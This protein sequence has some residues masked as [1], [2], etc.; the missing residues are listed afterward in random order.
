MPG[1]AEYLCDAASVNRSRNFRYQIRTTLSICTS[2]MI[3]IRKRHRD[4][5]DEF[6]L[7]EWSGMIVRTMPFFF[8][9]DM[10]KK[11]KG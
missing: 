6:H 1:N 10:L 4:N 7:N 5:P 2:Q 3:R 11:N 8:L 9:P